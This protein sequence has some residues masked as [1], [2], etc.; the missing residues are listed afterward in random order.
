M[1]TAS[2]VLVALYAMVLINKPVQLEMSDMARS[3]NGSHKRAR[4][5]AIKRDWNSFGIG[6]KLQSKSRESVLIRWDV[7]QGKRAG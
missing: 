2:I 7:Q 5:G 3:L 1:T 4:V 6:I